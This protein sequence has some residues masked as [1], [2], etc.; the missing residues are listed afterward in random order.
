MANKRKRPQDRSQGTGTRTPHLGPPPLGPHPAVTEHTITLS[1]PG[2][3][4]HME[5]HAVWTQG[6]IHPRLWHLLTRHYQQQDHTP[7]MI[8]ANIHDK[9]P[10]LAITLAIRAADIICELECQRPDSDSSFYPRSIYE[11]VLAT[12]ITEAQLAA[13]EA[14]IVSR[15]GCIT[16][17]QVSSP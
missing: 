16:I 11:Y 8:V 5:E 10:P 15:E 2:S 14:Q 13:I 6:Y 4:Y 9:I 1:G 7:H 17:R 3:I 12:R